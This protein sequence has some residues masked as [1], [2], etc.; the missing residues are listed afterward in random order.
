MTVTEFLQEPLQGQTSLSRVV[1]LY[2]I[3]GSLLFGAVELFLNPEN[4]FAMRV[5]TILG[6]FFGT[7]ITIATYRC[8]KNCKSPSLARFVRVCAVISLVLLPVLT[9]FDLT[10]QLTMSDL[11]QGGRLPE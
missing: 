5:Y 6:L 10:G 9:Y 4:Q 2:G 3:V 11:M 1:W 7:Y 8:A